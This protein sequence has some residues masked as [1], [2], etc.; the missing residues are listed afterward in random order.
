MLLVQ[1]SNKIR[2]KTSYLNKNVKIRLMQTA[3]FYFFV[4]IRSMDVVYFYFLFC[5]EMFILYICHQ[6]TVNL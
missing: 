1:I 3:Y 4:R 2:G 6:N 5:I